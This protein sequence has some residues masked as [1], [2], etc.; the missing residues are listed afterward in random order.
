MKTANFWSFVLGHIECDLHQKLIISWV[1]RKKCLFINLLQIHKLVVD[2]SC[3][4]KID[5]T[6][7]DTRTRQ[8]T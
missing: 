4:Q 1:V 8:S 3:L 5:Y 6:R 7:T 2:I